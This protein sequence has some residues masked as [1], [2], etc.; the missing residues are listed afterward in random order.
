MLD[1]LHYIIL[2]HYN[3]FE[4]NGVIAIHWY[5]Y[6]LIKELLDSVGG[7]VNCSQIN[8]IGNKSNTLVYYTI[9]FQV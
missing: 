3:S 4:Y 2:C 8:G 1:L 7:S 6:N 5:I 9:F